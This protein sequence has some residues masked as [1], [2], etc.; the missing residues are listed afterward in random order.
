MLK[1]ITPVYHQSCKIVQQ[2]YDDHCLSRAA[3]LAYTSL[4]ALVPL[5]TVSLSILAAFPVFQDV[6]TKIQDM[7]FAN[8]VAGSADVVQAHIKQFAEAATHLSV[9]GLVFLVITAVMM[10]FNMEL[11][12]N[13]IWRVEK[14]RSGVSAFLIY[15]AVLTLLPIF[16]G[17][18][19]ALSTY[20]GSLSFITGTAEALRI[21][22][23][24]LEYSPYLLTW[25]AFTLLYTTLPNCRVLVR[26]ALV[27]GLV[28]TLLFELA[29]RGFAYYISHFPTYQLLYG[30]LAAIPIFFVWIYL[31]WVVVLF[32][33]VV[34]HVVGEKNEISA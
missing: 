9:T 23:P 25:A 28:A 5:M 11:D 15:W 10:I 17:V 6:A 22:Q 12:F 4:L 32:G 30:A 3:A 34:A 13:A 1:F 7:V 8:F 27:G 26:H 16:I 2:F 21:K 18:G 24:L 31:S 29:K 19:F 20:L 33:A 14:R